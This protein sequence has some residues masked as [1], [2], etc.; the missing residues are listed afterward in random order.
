M[1]L[2]LPHG[3]SYNY[4]HAQTVYTRRSLSSPSAPGN[5]ANN[6]LCFVL[7]KDA[8]I[9]KNTV[10]HNHRLALI[11]NFLTKSFEAACWASVNWSVIR[12]Y[13]LKG[14]M[15]WAKYLWSGSPSNQPIR[16]FT[17]KILCTIIT[18]PLL[19]WCVYFKLDP[20]VSQ[21]GRWNGSGQN[22]PNSSIW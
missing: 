4:A 6:A 22:G 5:E 1:P 3:P 2:I 17:S 8:K 15:S 16:L 21:T 7:P 18:W 14:V 11:L 19:S 10:A 9:Q 12:I 20:K 13:K